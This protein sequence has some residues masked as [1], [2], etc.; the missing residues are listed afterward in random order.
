M[1]VDGEHTE[2][3]R[4]IALSQFFKF[5]TGERIQFLILES[6]KHL[7]LH[8]NQS[9]RFIPMDIVNFDAVIFEKNITIF[10][11]FVASE[12]KAASSRFRLKY[13]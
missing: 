9:V 4:F 5:A 2:K 12:S 10:K 11:L 3:K 6:P 7:I 1:R 8:E 13:P